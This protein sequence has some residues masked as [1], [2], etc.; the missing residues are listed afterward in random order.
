MGKY[1]LL[2]SVQSTP[3][4]RFGLNP[5]GSPLS[6]GKHYS[7]FFTP[8]LL[9]LA[10]FSRN[11]GQAH[12]APS[13]FFFNLLGTSLCSGRGFYGFSLSRLYIR[14]WLA[15]QERC[16][17]NLPKVLGQQRSYTMGLSCCPTPSHPILS[18]GV[19][20]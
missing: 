12:H 16:K 10:R 19:C 18:Y 2:T 15:L 3:I 17:L 11:L 20:E 4:G 8:L 7:S 6:D 13:R 14:L 5:L 1:R 9:G